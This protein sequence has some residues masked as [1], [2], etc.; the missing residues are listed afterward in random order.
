[1]GE[2]GIGFYNDLDRDCALEVRLK[3]PTP[4]ALANRNASISGDRRN[5]MA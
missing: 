3:R 4:A 2:V 5:E 1:M